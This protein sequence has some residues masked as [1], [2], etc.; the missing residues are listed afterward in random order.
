MYL[1][2]AK[3]RETSTLKPNRGIVTRL[4]MSSTTSTFESIANSLPD[5]LAHARECEQ[6]ADMNAFRAVLK[7]YS[8]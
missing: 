8:G 3:T 7:V 6:R 1:L 5:V 2:T 4:V